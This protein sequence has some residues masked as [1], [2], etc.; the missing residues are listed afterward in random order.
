MTEANPSTFSGALH[1]LAEDER[2]RS[3][4]HPEPD[5]L[6]AYH[7][8]E[9]SEEERER[10]QDHLAV[11]PRCARTVLDLASFPAIEPADP[12]REISDSEVAGARAALDRRLAEERPLADPVPLAHR[13]KARE[14]PSG[15]PRTAVF[16]LAAVFLATVLG[17]S[18]WIVS[19]RGELRGLE[20]TVAEL[21]TPAAGFEIRNPVPVASFRQR[22]EEPETLLLSA[23][24][25]VH[26][27][28]LDVA[29]LDHPLFPAYALELAGEDGEILWRQDDA[30]LTED[31]TVNLRLPHA[32]LP[33]GDYRIRLLGVDGGERTPLEEY[34]IRIA[35]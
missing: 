14:A 9:L 32:F 6:L 4:A 2:R 23:D 8:G 1:L 20:A 30:R 13:Q 33:P 18:F 12:A 15:I 24:E 19:L 11:C 27:L 3:D 34:P 35:G 28:T 7:A 21:R 29:L 22:G 31:G 16:P 26:L 25:P 10:L 17:L 5:D